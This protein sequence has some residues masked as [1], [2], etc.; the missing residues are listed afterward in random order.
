[1]ARY[2]LVKFERDEHGE[3]FCKDIREGETW[4]VPSP[5]EIIYCTESLTEMWQKLVEKYANAQG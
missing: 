1:M 5:D 2:A 3:E 4:D